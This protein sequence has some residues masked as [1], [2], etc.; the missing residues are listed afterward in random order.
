M[1]DALGSG[2]LALS[3]F[4]VAGVIV[5]VGHRITTPRMRRGDWQA[6]TELLT[7]EAEVSE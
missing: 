1:V 3:P 4:I 6:I 5:W 7:L 2:L